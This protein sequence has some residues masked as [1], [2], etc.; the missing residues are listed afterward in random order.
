MLSHLKVKGAVI[1]G[2][3]S[4]TLLGWGLNV[5]NINLELKEGNLTVSAKVSRED[6]LCSGYEF[7]IFFQVFSNL[8]II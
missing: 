7:G 4:A 5:T 3:L 1:I 8:W 6:K 2:I